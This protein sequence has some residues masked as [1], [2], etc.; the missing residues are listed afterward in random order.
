[1][2]NIRPSPFLRN[3]LLIAG[4]SLLDFTS[5]LPGRGREAM[6]YGRVCIESRGALR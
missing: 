4:A 6:T 5:F 2:S 1:M 3:A